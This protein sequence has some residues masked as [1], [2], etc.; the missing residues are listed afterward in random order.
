MFLNDNEFPKEYILENPYPNPFN[1]TTNIH[2]GLPIY[3]YIEIKVYDLNGKAVEVLEKKYKNPG[4]YSISWDASNH[5][6]G[7]YFIKL[8]SNGNNISTKKIMLLK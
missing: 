5:S 4:N 8:E 7:I 2:Y 3:S 1:P 6:S